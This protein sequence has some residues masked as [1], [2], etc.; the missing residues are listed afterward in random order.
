MEKLVEKF[1]RVAEPCGLEKGVRGGEGVKGDR[2]LAGPPGLPCGSVMNDQPGTD[3]LEL[4]Q[5]ILTI[6]TR[7][8]RLQSAETL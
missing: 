4:Y 2:G 7:L 1:W 6:Q 8:D 5:D 3:W